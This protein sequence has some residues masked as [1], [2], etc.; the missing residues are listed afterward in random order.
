MIEIAICGILEKTEFEAL[1]M[2]IS[3]ESIHADVSA[4]NTFVARGDDMKIAGVCTVSPRD[5]SALFPDAPRQY[6]ISA[7]GEARALHVLYGAAVARA[8]LLANNC[9]EPARVYA[10]VRV[11][12][13]EA[14]SVLHALGFQDGD[15]V[16]RMYRRVT[17]QINIARMPVG[18]TIVRDFLG[19]PL[20]RRYFLER[21]N[22]Y[23][24]L[25]NDDDWLDEITAQ[26]DFARI[27]MVSPNELC[28][29]LLVWT[30]DKMGVIGIV[31]T[32]RKWRRMGV[33]SY[34]IEDA[35]LYF[36]SLKL[37][38]SQFDVW[39]KAPG[40]MNLAR[41]AGYSGGDPIRLYPELRV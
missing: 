30:E 11:G 14:L 33:A 6:V 38:Y 16:T 13:E 23:Y 26:S 24:G 37:E 32:A 40:A 21:Y 22:A 20:E 35:R 2:K 28:G 8:R 10:D 34:L 27:L 15:G 12:D 17:N 7:S 36:A 18:C 31:Q 3:H 25:N 29:E 9:G 39:V 41:R 4:E 19:D 5:M 1:R